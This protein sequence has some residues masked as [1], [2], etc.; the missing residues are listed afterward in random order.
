MALPPPR[1]HKITLAAAVALT[2][3]FRETAG[4]KTERGG[5]FHR[6]QLDQL[7]AQPG[8][9]GL[10]FYQGRN[11]DGSFAMVLVGVDVTGSDM[12]DGDIL[13]QHYPCPPYCGDPDG[14]NS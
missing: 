3:R 7:L 8:C 5:M 13:E 10:R 4:P 14:L 1:D 11:A 9:M 6:A 2:R 12:T